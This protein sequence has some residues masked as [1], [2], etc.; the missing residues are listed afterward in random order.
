MKRSI[1]LVTLLLSIL[2]L[3][4]LSP[5]AGAKAKRA[6]LRNA[7][8]SL[9]EERIIFDGTEKQPGVV[10]TLQGETLAEGIDYTLDY[11]DNLHA[12]NASVQATGTGRFQGTVRK[13]FK[14]EKAE[15]TLHYDPVIFPSSEVSWEIPLLVQ[16]Q[17]AANLTYRSL[18][19]GVTVSKAGV[20][21]L[22][23]G[24]SG[25]IDIEIRASET[26]DYLNASERFQILVT[27]VPEWILACSRRSDGADL[28]WKCPN[29]ASFIEVQASEDE[30]FSQPVVRRISAAETSRLA[31]NLPA[32]SVRYFRLRSIYDFGG[33]EKASAWSKIQKI[34]VPQKVVFFASDYQSNKKTDPEISLRRITGVLSDHCFFPDMVVLCGDYCDGGSD[35][36]GD[37]VWTLDQIS[38]YLEEFF[39][40]FSPRSGFFA[41]QG[42][43]DRWD[44]SYKANGLYD[45]GAFYIYAMNT[46]TANPWRQHGNP[47][48]KEILTEAAGKFQDAMDRLIQSGETRPVFIATHVP[49]H[50]SEWTLS[51][52]NP[53]SR[54]LFEAVNSAAQHL[55]IIFL[56]AHNH[57]NHGD[58]AIGGSCTFIPAGGQLAVPSLEKDEDGKVRWAMET[59]HFNYMNA[60]Y[61]GYTF[62]DGESASNMGVC[63]CYSDRFEFFRYGSDGLMSL[64]APGF[65]RN[66]L[67]PP[68]YVT[69][70]I[71][72]YVLPLEHQ[73]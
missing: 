68:E 37:S 70:R 60:G 44:V 53:Y 62:T 49:L 61:V 24:F 57:G 12:G 17:A 36:G 45:C 5:A 2:C 71:P 43:H 33:K 35:Y 39:E 58:C 26:K 23:A 30:S 54:I 41:I 72:S 50:F 63:L 28:S 46:E 64:C 22:P 67:L 73:P 21:A 10:L 14:I 15:N 66:T 6:S 3:L 34:E 47:R 52:D 19:S 40:G 59:I 9:A 7:K 48:A 51:G 69:Q 55:P 20:L 25:F 13:S 32:G 18:T 8:I 1:R 27:D 29:G 31:W 65:R 11:K 56:F 42:N 16:D 4:C 38:G